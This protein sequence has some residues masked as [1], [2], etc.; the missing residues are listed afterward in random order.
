MRSEVFQ[1]V[2]SFVKIHGMN[3][4]IAYGVKRIIIRFWESTLLHM[5]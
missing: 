5:I 3:I 4:S 1:V 2:C